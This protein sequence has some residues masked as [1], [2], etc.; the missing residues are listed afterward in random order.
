[1]STVQ[2]R[3]RI[4]VQAV[5]YCARMGSRSFAGREMS[6]HHYLG[7]LLAVR[8]PPSESILEVCER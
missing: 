5:T 7:D 8:R 2:G 1:M 3:L 6:E 4:A